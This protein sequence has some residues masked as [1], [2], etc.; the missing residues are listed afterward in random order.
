MWTGRYTTSGSSPSL[1]VPV[2]RA[3]WSTFGHAETSGSAYR[4]FNK[5]FRAFPLRAPSLLDTMIGALMLIAA[6]T[7]AT[8][9]LLG[10]GRLCHNLP[11][12]AQQR[13]RSRRP[14]AAME[15]LTITLVGC[16]SG[17]GVGLDASNVVDMLKPDSPAAAELKLGDKVLLWNGIEMVDF[18]GER[19][20]L[21][22][23]VVPAD[24]HTLVIERQ[25]S[26]AAAGAQ[27]QRA[28]KSAA[29][30]AD[31]K[32]SSWQTSV[33]LTTSDSWKSDDAWEPESWGG[34]TP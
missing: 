16:S 5:R 27:A 12:A 23:V 14:M 3:G 22:D 15:K 4:L 20:L 26:A 6:A 25:Q 31:P 30:A 24:A 33:P 29:A 1:E 32:E 21:K 17:V 7:Q 34:D 9:L 28:A 11:A 8:G 10:S 13:S 18:T 2:R 19:R